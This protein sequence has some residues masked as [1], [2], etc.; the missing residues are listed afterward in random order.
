MEKAEVKLALGSGRWARRGTVRL[1]ADSK[2]TCAGDGD[3][4]GALLTSLRMSI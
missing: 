1:G 4:G 3:K 2:S